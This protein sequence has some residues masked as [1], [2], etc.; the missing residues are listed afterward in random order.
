MQNIP[1]DYSKLL[2]LVFTKKFLYIWNKADD[3]FNFYNRRRRRHT[4]QLNLELYEIILHP[5]LLH[6]FESIL[7]IGVEVHF[8]NRLNHEFFNHFG[9]GTT[10]KGNLVIA[11]NPEQTTK[12]LIRG[13]VHELKHVQDHYLE[14][15]THEDIVQYDYKTKEG[16]KQYR[17][18][19]YERR[20]ELFTQRFIRRLVKE[21]D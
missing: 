11:F 1:I 16:Y 12:E 2:P 14:I 20:A 18:L 9:S 5:Y 4:E 21:L 6:H 7:N 13:F 10:E 19:W 3:A 8:T 15:L 17:A